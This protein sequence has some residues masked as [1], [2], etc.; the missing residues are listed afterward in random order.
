MT[1]DA[2]PD[3]PLLQVETLTKT[4]GGFTALDN[5]SASTVSGRAAYRIVS[6][7]GNQ[8]L[9]WTLSTTSPS[10]AGILALKAAP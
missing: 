6:T 1:N 7:A 5:F 10:G 4:F 2:A 8:S 9:A 3:T